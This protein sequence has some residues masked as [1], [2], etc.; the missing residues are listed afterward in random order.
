MGKVMRSVRIL[1]LSVTAV[2]C[3]L[4][5]FGNVNNV[6]INE[7]GTFYIVDEYCDTYY[8]M[9]SEN[10]GL[11]TPNGISN[12]YVNMKADGYSIYKEDITNTYVDVSFIKVGCP[13]YRFYYEHPSGRITFF[14]SDYE[15][16]FTG[17]AYINDRK[18]KSIRQ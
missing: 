18:G 5:T 10:V 15:S 14:S 7:I 2:V 17:V 9:L 13:S 8:E 12:V 16:S 4:I 11:T 3:I 1:V 6:S